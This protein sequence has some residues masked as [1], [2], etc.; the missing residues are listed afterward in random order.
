MKKIFAILLA[1]VVAFS[2]VAEESK[3]SNYIGVGLNGLYSNLKVDG[4][5]SRSSLGGGANLSILGVNNLS[6]LTV[7]VDFTLGAS[8]TKDIP[9]EDRL[10]G[11]FGA[12]DAGI[13][14]SF[15]H[16]EDTVLSLLGVIS[17]S[18][19]SYN[20]DGET[21]EEAIKLAEK[22]ITISTVG[23]GADVTFVQRIS[24]NLHFFASANAR[25]IW[26]GDEDR[27]FSGENDDATYYK[28]I[29]RNLEG[30]IELVPTLGVM[31]KIK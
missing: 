2:A 17:A 8:S 13:G 10:T 19:S 6:G 5:G 7:K 21:S 11:L 12:L 18:S 23:I 9:A 1:S 22:N 25:Y 31:W 15:I 27:K 28:G 29:S 14:Y 16:N 24:N 20:G 26:A 3:Y 30:T 4:D